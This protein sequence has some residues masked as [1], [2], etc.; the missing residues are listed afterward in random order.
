MIGAVVH[1]VLSIPIALALAPFQQRV[2]EQLIN[3]GTVPP[4]VRDYFVSAV[5]GSLGLAIGFFFMLIA[6]VIFATLGGLL[7]AAIFRKPQPPIVADV[8]PSL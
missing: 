6:G 1:L 4:E 5:G 3:S 7:G 2:V 8:P